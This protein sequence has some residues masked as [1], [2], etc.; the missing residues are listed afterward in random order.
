MAPHPR[1]RRRGQ[2]V[3][4]YL[5]ATSVIAIALAAGFVAFSGGVG[6]VFE[7]VRVTVQQPYP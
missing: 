1:A 7:N 4:E 2:S 6:G 5:L 3:V